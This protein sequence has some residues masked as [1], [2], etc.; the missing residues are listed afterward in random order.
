MTWVQHVQFILLTTSWCECKEL[1][2]FWLELIPT[3]TWN[4]SGQNVVSFPTVILHL[5]H[6]HVIRKPYHFVITRVTYSP[7][8][9]IFFI[10]SGHAT[11]QS[12]TSCDEQLAVIEKP[13]HISHRWSH[14][15]IICSSNVPLSF[16]NC[17]QTVFR[18]VLPPHRARFNPDR[19][20]V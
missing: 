12:V 15:V 4:N 5:E 3:V 13:A 2:T 7:V 17:T 10:A 16:V 9:R 14:A 8:S 11:S 19:I 20:A 18:C 1:M 6:F